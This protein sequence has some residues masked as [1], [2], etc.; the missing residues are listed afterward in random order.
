LDDRL[1]SL[2]AGHEDVD[3]DDCGRM[4]ALYGER[5][6][7]VHR[8]EDLVAFHLEQHLQ[9]V[10][11]PGSSSTIRTRVLAPAIVPDSAAMEDMLDVYCQR[12]GLEMR[13]ES[14]R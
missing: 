3:H 11:T 1:D 10:R 2:G 5:L 4:L 9:E 12:S 6:D 13:N 8:R 14:S 7:T